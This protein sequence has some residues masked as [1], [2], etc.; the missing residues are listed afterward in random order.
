MLHIEG[1]KFVEE[2]WLGH[3]SQLWPLMFSVHSEQKLTSNRFRL[4]WYLNKTTWN[5]IKFQ[6]TPEYLPVKCDVIVKKNCTGYERREILSG[7]C[8]TS[9]NM[10]WPEPQR[11]CDGANTR[12]PRNILLLWTGCHLDRLINPKQNRNLGVVRKARARLTRAVAHPWLSAA[13]LLLLKF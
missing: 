3:Y 8:R 4:T 2:E 5:F 6:S 9:L 7:V 10:A 1:A 13:Q 11:R 12:R